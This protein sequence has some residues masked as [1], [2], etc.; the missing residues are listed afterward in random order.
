MKT[1]TLTAPDGTNIVG[2]LA[3]DGSTRAFES[4]HLLLGGHHHSFYE[5]PESDWGSTAELNGD[6]VLVDANGKYWLGA[7]VQS[8]SIPQRA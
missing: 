4:K 6:I 3:K 7:D 2:F 1:I 5:I 8:A